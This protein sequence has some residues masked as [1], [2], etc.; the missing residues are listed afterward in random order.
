VA[1]MKKPIEGVEYRENNGC[2]SGTGRDL[3]GGGHSSGLSVQRFT[4]KEACEGKSTSRLASRVIQRQSKWVHV[5]G[6]GKTTSAGKLPHFQK[7]RVGST[8]RTAAA[9]YHEKECCRSS[10]G[11]SEQKERLPLGKVNA[12]R[13]RLVTWST[14][15]SEGVGAGSSRNRMKIPARGEEYM[16]TE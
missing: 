16:K 2:R 1:M 6:R 7:D 9:A 8:S 10:A 14:H 15:E 4:S 12:K 11:K 5:T 13:Y 3:G